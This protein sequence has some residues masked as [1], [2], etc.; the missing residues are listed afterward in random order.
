MIDGVTPFEATIL[1]G[2]GRRQFV[3][4]QSPETGICLPL[5]SG[6]EVTLTARFKGELDRTGLHIRIETSA[7]K[8]Y[9]GP[10][11]GQPLFRYEYDAAHTSAMPRAHLQ[12]GDQSDF[13]ALASLGGDGSRTSRRRNDRIDGGLVPRSDHLHFPVGG[14][15]FR[16][17]LEDVLKMLVEQLGVDALPDWRAT[18]KAARHRWRTTQVKSAVRDHPAAAAEAL[19]AL[20]Y[21]VVAPESGHP[22]PSARLTEI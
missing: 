16:P 7:I 9:F 18:V 15:R 14:D 10:A 17:A 11:A 12:V 21:D 20:G 13:A 6:S 22:N 5:S 3:V 2:S 4:R 1:E 8:V 19:Q